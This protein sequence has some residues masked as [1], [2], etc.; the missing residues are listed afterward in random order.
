MLKDY[1]KTA[2]PWS[3]KDPL[4]WWQW[5]KEEPVVI[6]EEN[7][8]PA[9]KSPEQIY[10]A[11]R[12]MG[13]DHVRY[14]AICWGAHFYKESKS[15]PKF[16]ALEPDSDC[17]GDVLRYMRKK[18]VKVMAYN[19]YGVLYR[20]LE[21]L[22]PDWL[23]RK[24]DGSCWVWNDMHRMAC[25][26]SDSFIE[27]MQ[28]A[29]SEVLD[30][31]HPDSIYLDGPT[32]YQ[33]DCH[34]EWCRRKY[35][36]MF[37]EELPDTLSE[38]DG[39]LYKYYQLRDAVHIRVV[40]G[41][42]EL[43]QRAGVPL[44]INTIM[45]HNAGRRSGLMELAVAKCEGA[46]TTEVNRTSRFW[47]IM[48]CAKLGESLKRVSM[49]YCPPG[50]FE[51]LRTHN[52]LETL[53]TGISYAMHGGSLMLQPGI[54]YFHDATGSEIMKRLMGIL[55]ENKGMFYRT[56]P[57]KETALVLN[58]T[59]FDAMGNT[60]QRKY[61]MNC[62]LGAFEALA[63]GHRHFDCMT[64]LQLSTER[65]KDYKVLFMPIA[66]CFDE[67]RRN[68]LEEYV[69][70]GGTIILGPNASLFNEDGSKRDSFD[71]EDL[72]GV[73]F[74]R[75]N[76]KSVIRIRE[77]RESAH[78]HP[79]AKIPE[80]YIRLLKNVG[81]MKADNTPLIITSD[82]VAGNHGLLHNRIVDYNIVEALADT[83]ILAELFLPAGGAFGEPF[84]F[85]EGKPPAV[86][87]HVYGKGMVIYCASHPWER[88]QVRG[89][90]EQRDLICGILDFALRGSPV[91]LSDAP[92][93]VYCNLTEDI[94]G[95]YLHL[96]NYCGTKFEHSVAV[97][98][99]APL[100]DL[101][102]KVRC[103][104]EFNAIDV[105]FAPGKVTADR[106]DGYYEI[107]LSELGVHQTIRML[108]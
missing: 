11:V 40:E 28:T 15:L 101:K 107:K 74:I 71:L 63:H 26:A 8:L 34:C 36:E 96:L 76:D 82:S 18:G 27:A 48:L 35:H 44:T 91:L 21:D 72:M 61:L 57:V 94:N 1:S 92:A 77:Y 95:R 78:V 17:F 85:P 65:I 31:Y 50:P 45:H 64:D 23:A 53:L 49:A 67:Y 59:T 75:E 43:T 16:S 62:Y 68:V 14:P 105:V 88:Y 108:Y 20:E 37:G 84:G 6:I 99:V 97:D 90:K 80:A 39:T 41:I 106:V 29:I 60:P 25:L 102:F 100:Y 9:W 89:L 81:S 4:P 66:A 54:S 30:I 33:G 103:D 47:P 32:W 69:F 55:K 51:S 42:H 58:N 104:R 93:G 38:K 70:N 10:R 5:L 46:N 2:E 12:D 7:E 87:S 98:W 56:Q 13:A 19:H 79:Y 83:D 86:T 52:F 73:R 24:R 3:I 22:H